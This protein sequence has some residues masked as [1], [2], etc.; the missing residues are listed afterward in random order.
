MEIKGQFDRT[1]WFEVRWVSG[2][3]WLWLVVDGGG[4]KCESRSEASRELG[5]PD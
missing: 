4:V 1:C 2:Y 3:W 5:G